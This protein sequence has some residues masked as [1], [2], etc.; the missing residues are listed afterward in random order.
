MAFLR[1]TVTDPASNTVHDV[2]LEV[3][4]ET[5]IASVLAALPVEVGERV[6]HAGRLPLDPHGTV[7]DSPLTQGCLLCVGSPVPDHRAVPPGAAGVL[8]VAAGP[9][10]GR[11]TW[12]TEG[13]RTVV[14]RGESADLVVDDP[15]V[16]RAHAEV[17]LGSGTGR[18]VTVRDRGSANGTF[19]A[20]GGVEDGTPL[21]DGGVF[22][23]GASL[24]QWIPLER[25]DDDWRRSPDGR[26]EFTRRFHSAPATV[27]ATV[28]LPA[29]PPGPGRG[30]AFLLTGLALPVLLGATTALITRTPTFLLMALLSPVTA[31]VQQVVERRARRARQAAF[32]AGRAGAALEIAAAVTAQEQVRRVNDPDELCLTLCALGALPRLWTKRSGAPDALTV[33][34]GTRDEPAAVH[35][36]GEPWDGFEQPMLRAVPVTVDLRETGV[37]GLVGDRC[38][39]EGLARWVLLQLA[40]RRSPEDLSLVVLSSRDG[41]HLRWTRWLPHTDPGGDSDVPCRVGVTGPSSAQRVEELRALVEGRSRERGAGDRRAVFPH[42]TVVLLDGARDLRELSGMRTVLSLG[43]DVGV[44]TIC[45]DSTDVNE[46]RGRVTVDAGGRAEVVRRFTDPAE[47]AVAET[48]SCEDAERLARLLAPMRDRAHASAEESGIPY[49][50]R[51]LDLVGLA[52]PGPEAVRALWEEEPGPTMRVPLGADERGRVDVDLVQQGPHTMLGGTTGA[53]KSVLMQTLITSL[54]LHNR[55]D[56]LN[57]VLV[58]FKGGGAFLPFKDCPQVVGLILSTGDDAAGG[59]FGPADADRVLGSIRGEVSRRERLLARYGGEIDEYLRRR[60]P[61][62]PPLPRLLLVFDEFARVLDVSRGFLTEL[63]T[64][65]GKGRSLGM[66]LLLA[67][68]SLEG[69]LTGE[70]K[71]NIDLRIS[72]R[73]NGAGASTEILEVPDAARIP[74]RLRGRGLILCTKD[75]SRTARPFQSGYLGGESPGT[76]TVPTRS[77]IVDWPAVGDPRPPEERPAP[78]G[79]TDQDAVIRAIERAGAGTGLPPPF[80]PLLPPLPAALALA[81][82]ERTATGPCPPRAVPFALADLPD[83]QAQPVECL[84]LAGGTRLMIAGGPQSGRTTAIRALIHAAAAR[85]SPDELHLYLLEHQPDGPCPYAGL[86]HWGGAFG[87]AEPDRVR[88]P[89]TWLAAETD[90]RAAARGSG[91]GPSPALLVLVDGWE[92]LHDPGDP[93]A[94]ETSLVRLVRQIIKAGPPLGVHLV[95]ACDRGPFR[96]RTA[97]LFDT[98]LALMFPSEDVLN[99]VLRSGTAR[100]ARIPGRAVEI[101]TGRHVQIARPGEPAGA[102]VERCS[103]LRCSP[104]PAPRTFPPLPDRVD[105]ACLARPGEATDGWFPLGVGGPDLDPVGVDLFAGPQCLL[106]SGPPGSGRSTAAAGVVSALAGRGVGCV[107]LCTPRSPVVR[108]LAGRP[109]VSVLPGPTLTDDVVRTAARA[110]GT[111]RVVVVAD[112][113]EQLTLTPTTRSFEELPTLPAEATTPDRLGTMGLV[114]CGDAAALLEGPRRSLSVVTRHVLTEGTRLVLAPTTRAA[115]REHGLTLEADQFFPGPPGRGY[116]VTGRD[117]ALVQLALHPDGRGV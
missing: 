61:G 44:Y 115:A 70:M 102:L 6:V 53:G 89:I 35:L 99:G 90:R 84:P 76:G 117:T 92:L 34:V 109:A 59:P 24:V 40:T 68:Q 114:L 9:D 63:V 106:V 20:G 23:V 45:V 103:G 12:V 75:E 5:T 54:L 88:R 85:F 38:V 31:A 71:N 107:V 93:T 79:D 32:A 98:R 66:H 13:G 21:P 77:R 3:L 1:C 100:P 33:R 55:P 52:E 91:G 58:D 64:V 28:D 94:V 10:T 101:G 48:T 82:L 22:D 57:L 67:T 65:T 110:L 29:A 43:P 80:R 14:G 86:P 73:Q 116:L 42:D 16:S 41:D 25:V 95:V 83:E 105:V 18:T 46:C 8:R 49:P 81:D 11:W 4:P 104:G 108:W 17:L 96:G 62:E 78:A 19:V 112:D 37:L 36:R 39:A 7:A 51:F 47:P 27:P 60:P 113:C 30:A 15:L 87:P 50:V 69:K 2:E 72:L 74:G 111:D 56:E 26:I 97:D